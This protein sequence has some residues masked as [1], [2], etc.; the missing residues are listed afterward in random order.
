MNIHIKKHFMDEMKKC[1]ELSKSDEEIAHIKA[2]ELL[3]EVLILLG[4]RDLV[5]LYTRVNKWY[6]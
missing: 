6:A 1:I 2:D 5:D 3:E 4:H